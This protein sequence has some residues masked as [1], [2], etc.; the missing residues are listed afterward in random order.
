MCTRNH[1]MDRSPKPDAEVLYLGGG[2]VKENMEIVDYPFPEPES[3]SWTLDTRI[4]KAYHDW[5]K[6]DGN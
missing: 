5:H 6:R 1:P 4:L 2:F 3:F